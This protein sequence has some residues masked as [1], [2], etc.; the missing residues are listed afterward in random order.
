[1]FATMTIKEF[2]TKFISELRTVY[3]T[4]EASSIAQIAFDHFIKKSPASLATD[5]LKEIEPSLV[6]VLNIALV[7]LLN[8]VPIQYIT[9]RAW[10]YNI[11]FAVTDA[12]L[13]PRP[14]TEELVL[15]IIHFLKHQ[16]PKKILDIGT[17]SGCIPISIKKN[18]PSVQISSLDVSAKALDIAKQ[19]AIENNT[20][21]NFFQFDFLKDQ[22]YNRL[23]KYDIIVSNPPYIP[24][25]EKT[26][27]DKNVTDYEPHLALFVPD[28]DRLLFY[29]KILIFATEH[30]EEGGRIFLEVHEDF[31]KETAEIFIN[32]N[33]TVIIKK[34]M[35]GKERMLIVS[36]SL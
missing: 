24:L 12:V 18:M 11:S 10:F 35:Q 16:T 33:Y 5:G 34:D 22:N 17:G 14:E 19:N 9:G 21:I 23:S 3:P 25:N 27:L 28:N 15:E 31:A 20:D 2:Y 32:S 8:N 13:I 4:G 6:E 7:E 1:M 26:I 30:L 36:R 29:K